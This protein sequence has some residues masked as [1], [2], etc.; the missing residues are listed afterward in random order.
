MVCPL[1]LCS[2]ACA[3]RRIDKT[4]STKQYSGYVGVSTFFLPAFSLSCR[5][6]EEILLN[7]RENSGQQDRTPPPPQVLNINQCNNK[8]YL[9]VTGSQIKCPGHREAFPNRPKS[10]VVQSKNPL[11][12]STLSSMVLPFLPHF[13]SYT[14]VKSC[15][16]KRLLQKCLCRTR[17]PISQAHWLFSGKEHE[18]GARSAV[19]YLCLLCP[20]VHLSPSSRPDLQRAPVTQTD[21]RP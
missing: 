5:K 3:H 19:I 12:C 11:V 15:S 18:A 1:C 2:S 8:K 9:I 21:K 16:P 13:V 14:S 6:T 17:F 10:S 20:S 7:S 4:A